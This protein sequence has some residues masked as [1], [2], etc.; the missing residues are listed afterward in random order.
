MRLPDMA[1][2][3]AEGTWMLGGD[4]GCAKFKALAYLTFF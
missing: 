3:L 4:R 1:V 2:L